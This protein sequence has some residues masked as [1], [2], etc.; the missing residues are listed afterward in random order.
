MTMS[1]IDQ[2]KEVVM[3]E[4]ND[5]YMDGRKIIRITYGCPNCGET[6]IAY[7]RRCPKCEQHLKW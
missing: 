4:D 1:E 2:P 3:Y 6:V 5:G 7:E